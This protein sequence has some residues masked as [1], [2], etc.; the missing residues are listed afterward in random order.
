MSGKRLDLRPCPFCNYEH[1]VL[2]YPVRRVIC[3]SCAACGPIGL[4]TKDAELRWNLRGRAAVASK[5]AE[6]RAALLARWWANTSDADLVATLES[7]SDEELRRLVNDGR[8]DHKRGSLEVQHARARA[9][10]VAV[11]L[12]IDRSDGDLAARARFLGLTRSRV[13]SMVR[14][15]L[16]YRARACKVADAAAHR[17]RANRRR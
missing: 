6:E 17:A 16:R 5:A 12:L 15:G 7:M 9:R 1:P 3:P 11:S 14:R 8:S 2:D 13:H 4:M 10:T